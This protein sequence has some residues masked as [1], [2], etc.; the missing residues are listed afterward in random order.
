MQ[1]LAREF[2]LSDDLLPHLPISARR[3]G[4][5]VTARLFAPRGGIPEAPATGPATAILAA[6]L[7]AFGA[8]I[9]G[10]YTSSRQGVETD[11]PSEIGLSIEVANV[12][13]A[14]IRIALP[15]R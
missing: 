14:E 12:A 15:P 13:V 2:K 9:D 10:R 5:A 8:L 3:A 11:R 7:R 4:V 6:L 1:V